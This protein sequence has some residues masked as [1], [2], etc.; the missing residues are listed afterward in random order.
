MKLLTLLLIIA[1][2]PLALSNV[3]Y[4][5][6]SQYQHIL[7]KEVDNQRCLFFVH[8]ETTI[9]HYQGCLYPAK[10]LVQILPFSRNL[11]AS[12][13]VMP[14]PKRVLVIGMGVGSVPM[15]IRHGVPGAFIETVDLD[16][17]VIEIAK[18]Y[19]QY[20]D[21]D[22]TRS[23]V[24]DGRVFVKAALEKGIRYDLIIL[25]AMNADYIPEHMLT[26]EFL[27]E[28]KGLLTDGGV[29]A[30]NTFAGSQ[31]YAHESN[32]YADVFGDFYNMK[33]D[34]KRSNRIIVASNAM[35]AVPFIQANAKRY[36]AL[37]WGVFGIN[38]NE[39]LTRMDD[40]KDWDQ[41]ARILTD[42]YSPSNLLNASKPNLT[43]IRFFVFLENALKE[44]TSTTIGVML[45]IV[46]MFMFSVGWIV[47]K[48][49]RRFSPL[50]PA[51]RGQ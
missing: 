29:V 19:F 14:E 33:S 22:M 34:D 9:S 18:K 4:E 2:P 27:R 13:L 46:V 11:L 5:G 17:A 32:T 7:V 39:L 42:Q 50:K 23:Y 36:A 49:Q 31:L 44:H 6:E 28:V 51:T 30:A 40:E 35:P 16:P 26:V 21:D 8:P 43:A 10:P 12:L 45:L 48:L 38:V 1:F 37:Y 47:T 15:A 24:A 25:D 41:S 3:L 20:R